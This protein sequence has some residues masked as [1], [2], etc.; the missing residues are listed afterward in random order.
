[1]VQLWLERLWELPMEKGPDLA[2]G[3]ELC[4]VRTLELGIPAAQ[5]LV[6]LLVRW[7]AMGKERR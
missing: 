6:L 1:M 4:Q 3:W 5:R 7:L 2:L